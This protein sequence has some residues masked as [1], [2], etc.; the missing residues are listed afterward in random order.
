MAVANHLPYPSSPRSEWPRGGAG[1]PRGVSGCSAGGPHDGLVLGQDRLRPHRR[2]ALKG[3]RRIR[4]DEGTTLRDLRLRALQCD[5]DAF[6]SNYEREVQQPQ[7]SWDQRAEASSTGHDQ[8]LFVAEL[9]G[10][11]VGMAGAYPPEDVPMVRHLIGMWVGPEARS[12]GFGS[13]LVA[14]IIAWGVDTG[15]TELRLWVVDTNETARR[16]HVRAGFAMTERIQALPSDPSVA[17]LLRVGRTYRWVRR[18]AR[19]RDVFVRGQLA[20]PNSGHDDPLAQRPYEWDGPHA[21]ALGLTHVSVASR[22]D[23]LSRVWAWGETHDT[24]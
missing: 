17:Q 20:S 19:S 23:R 1:R 11:V 14:S 5:P 10:S 3:V 18:G 2:A 22:C 15:A 13:K 24:Q 6:G 9:D 8:C 12:G 16:R 4:P 7:E 21:V